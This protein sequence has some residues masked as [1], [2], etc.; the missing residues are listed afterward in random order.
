M[1]AQVGF[2][3][4]R[5]G[6]TDAPL[7]ALEVMRMSVVMP[8][9][10][11]ATLAKRPARVRRDARLL[12]FPAC[13]MSVPPSRRCLDRIVRTPSLLARVLCQLQDFFATC[14]GSKQIGAW[15]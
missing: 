13:P 12:L 2:P 1:S 7:A 8:T 3:G 4:T 5:S 9:A 14:T 11:T 6:E 15:A 10:N